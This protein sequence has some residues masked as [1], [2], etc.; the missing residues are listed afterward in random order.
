MTNFTVWRFAGTQEEV[1]FDPTRGSEN[2]GVSMARRD[3]TASATISVLHDP[4]SGPT[5]QPRAGRRD[6]TDRRGELSSPH[7]DDRPV[8]HVVG[9]AIGE[10]LLPSR[11][12]RPA[13]RVVGHAIGEALP[14]LPSNRPEGHVLGRA[15]DEALP[16]L[17]GDRPIGHVLAP[18]RC[19]SWGSRA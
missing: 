6:P 11:R 19:M 15:V 10:V 2:Q 4:T 14:S 12:D 8:G 9:R 7:R 17:R 3:P 16:K 13:G 18:Q 5:T 1:V